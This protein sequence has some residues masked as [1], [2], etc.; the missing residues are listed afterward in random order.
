V[1]TGSSLHPSARPETLAVECYAASDS[2]GTDRGDRHRHMGPELHPG[3]DGRTNGDCLRVDCLGRVN[4]ALW[5]R[6]KLHLWLGREK[7]NRANAFSPESL[8]ELASNR[9]PGR[10]TQARKDSCTGPVEELTERTVASSDHVT[11]GLAGQQLI[12]NAQRLQSPE[13]I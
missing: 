2:H 6:R 3:R 12:F 10:S 8:K 7:P 4:A 5:R 13:V 1:G 9:V 11:E